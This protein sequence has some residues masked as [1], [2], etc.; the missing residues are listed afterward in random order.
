[1]GTTKAGGSDFLDSEA[2]ATGTTT[3]GE[4]SPVLREGVLFPEVE[5][6]LCL[7]KRSFRRV[8]NRE[9][10]P[11]GVLRVA[12]ASCC[13]SAL[14]RLGVSTV[15]PL[16]VELLSDESEELEEFDVS[17]VSGVTV[18]FRLGV[19]VVVSSSTR[20]RIRLRRTGCSVEAG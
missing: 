8:S 2:G 7:F 16:L 13:G 20:R 4:E 15:E 3:P 12:G 9:G 14:L 17:G 19:V 1:M 10:E 11:S 18:R 6:C 5:F